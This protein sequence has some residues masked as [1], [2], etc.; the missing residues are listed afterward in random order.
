MDYY[1]LMKSS[2]R[3]IYIFGSLKSACLEF[4]RQRVLPRLCYGNVQHFIVNVKPKRVFVAAKVFHL[5]QARMR[6][7][8]T[9]ADAKQ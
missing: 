7:G 3:Q 4:N 2:R 8:L 6:L 5:L 1:P 9:F